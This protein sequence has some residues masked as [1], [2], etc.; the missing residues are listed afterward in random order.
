[1]KSYSTK[2]LDREAH[3][4]YR[5]RS[6]HALVVSLLLMIGGH[7][8]SAGPVT[9]DFV[10]ST[11]VFADTNKTI[12]P[13]LD[14]S[15]VTGSFDYDSKAPLTGIRTSSLALT[16]FDFVIHTVT[17]M[18]LPMAT[19]DSGT[20]K[21]NLIYES[22]GWA[23]SGFADPI[24]ATLPT[25]GATLYSAAI[26]AEVSPAPTTLPKDL[27]LFS[28][29]TFTLFFDVPGYFLRPSAQYSVT[30]ISARSSG[31]SPTTPTV[32]EPSVIALLVPG[33]IGLRIMRKRYG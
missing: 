25:K 20:F 32:P 10:A 29:A 9:Y 24:S 21:T 13:D 26:R 19:S 27:S 6:T 3:A 2:E 1:M 30:G 31:G 15:F 28:S 8:A 12:I 18:S 5:P 22:Y 14:R 11:P 7:T 33:I 4:Y 17:G 23:I 16:N